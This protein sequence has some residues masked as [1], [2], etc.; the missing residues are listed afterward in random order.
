MSLSQ[1][2]GIGPATQKKLAMAGVK[3]VSDLANSDAKELSRKTDVSE[4][5]ISTFIDRA[6]KKNAPKKVPK[7]KKELAELT[8][9]INKLEERVELLEDHFVPEHVKK[10]AS[11]IFNH[12]PGWSPSQVH[13]FL[14]EHGYSKQDIDSALRYIQKQ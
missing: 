2:K 13:F 1:I 3:T 6:G 8:K 10:L 12:L 7:S 11:Y 9:R 14:K 4:K 5:K